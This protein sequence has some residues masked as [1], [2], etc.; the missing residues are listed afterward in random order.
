MTTLTSAWPP[1][2]EWE[3]VRTV[4][5]PPSIVVKCWGKWLFVSFVVL[6]LSYRVFC[7]GVLV[8]CLCVTC[9][10]SHSHADA[11]AFGGGER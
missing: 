9:F 3:V 10:S 4:A 7:G 11:A 1:T 2:R 5:A 8:V 6:F